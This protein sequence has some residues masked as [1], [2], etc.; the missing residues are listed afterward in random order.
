MCL[1]FAGLHLHEAYK[2]HIWAFSFILI[3]KFNERTAL[4]P[5]LELLGRKLT[6]HQT[7]QQSQQLLYLQQRTLP[8][9]LCPHCNMA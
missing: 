6:L 5:K 7:S 9:P 4:K 8:I 3:H 1:P 2:H